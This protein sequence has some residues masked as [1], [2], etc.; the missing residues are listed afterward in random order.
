MTLTGVVGKQF[1][2][3]RCSRVSTYTEGLLWTMSNDSGVPAS[4]RKS[5]SQWGLCK[6]EFS[7][8]GHFP[9]A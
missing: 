3:R 1:R 8:T 2:G 9:V 6:D 4:V 5:M 7:A